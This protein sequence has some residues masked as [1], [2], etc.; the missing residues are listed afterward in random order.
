MSI[1]LEELRNEYH[2]MVRLFV[3]YSP[4]ERSFHKGKA[5]KPLAEQYRARAQIAWSLYQ[6][7]KKGKQ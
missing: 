3:W 1:E 6:E 2:E 7:K 4:C 5:S